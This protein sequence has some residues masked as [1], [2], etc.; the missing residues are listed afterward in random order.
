MKGTAELFDTG[1][2]LGSGERHPLEN[3]IFNAVLVITCI[4]SVLTTIYNIVLQNNSLVVACSAVSILPTT[5]V[6]LY[7]RKTGRHEHLG[8]PVFIYYLVVMI[9]NWVSNAGTLGAGGSFFFLLTTI[10]VLLVK[11]SFLFV[12]GC[13]S[14]TLIA[15]LCSEY[16]FG[17]HFWGYASDSQR[18]F[19]VSI[20][21]LICLMMTGAIIYAV[22]REY[23]KER[24]FSQELLQLTLADKQRIEQ[25]HLIHQVLLQEVNHRTKN[26][27][28]MIIAMLNLQGR[29]YPEPSVRAVLNDTEHRIRA[30]A[31]VHER[32]YCSH[33]LHELDFGKYLQDIVATLVNTIVLDN[34]ITV[35]FDLVP[36]TLNINIAIPLALAMNEM[37]TNALKHAFPNGRPGVVYV[38]LRPCGIDF[39]EV[40][41]SDD[42]VGLTLPLTAEPADSFGLQ[43]I[44]ELIVH[45]LKGQLQITVG[46]GTWFTALVPMLKNS[47]TLPAAALQ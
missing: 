35:L 4:T 21:L 19:D 8:V 9:I 5:I 25:A 16:K 2:L 42:G 11:R 45:Q 27:M 41:L 12:M 24:Q 39:F 46:H 26:N 36:V 31:L 28:L 29:R 7:S 6:Y 32:L 1:W 34:R 10:A 13:I 15:L 20:S 17:H 43:I 44:Q 22:F 47:T 30:M 23:L 3:R 14:A 40:E 38:G 18:F 37:V 33:S